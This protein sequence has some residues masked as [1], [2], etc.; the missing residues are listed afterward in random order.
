MDPAVFNQIV[1]PIFEMRNALLICISTPLGADN[2]YSELMDLTDPVTNEYVFHRVRV[3]PLCEECQAKSADFCPHLGPTDVPNWKA[4][5]DSRKSR[6]IQL[7]YG[8]DKEVRAFPAALLVRIFPRSSH[9]RIHGR[10]APGNRGSRQRP[11][12][13]AQGRR[14]ARQR[15]C[16]VAHA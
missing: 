11:C 10:K 1:L 14:R 6:H 13:I 8:T 4:A 5:S 3:V 7:M 15:P 2:F 16:A 9:D 12:A